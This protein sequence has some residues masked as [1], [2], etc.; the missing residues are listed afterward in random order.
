MSSILK[1][2]ARAALDAPLPLG[3]PPRN[4]RGVPLDPQVHRMM[5]ILGLA[6]RPTID[7]LGAERARRELLAQ[8][9][10][11]ARAAVPVHHVEDRRI[12][13]EEGELTVRVYVPRGGA[14]R[15]PATVYY[16]GGGFV[17]GDLESHDA[18][19]RHLAVRGGCVVVAVHYRLAPEHPFPA[20]VDDA[21]AAFAWVV[22][23]AGALG[24]DPARVAVAGDSAGGNLAAVVSQVARD[25]GGPRPSFQLL[26]YPATD[27][28]RSLASHRTFAEGYFLTEAM[29]DWF[30]ASYLT[31][32]EQQHDPRASPLRARDLTGL[33]PAHVV[34]AG[35]DPLRDEGE[36][37]ADALRA[38]GVPAT[39]RCYDTMIHGFVSMAG[40][41]DAAAHATDDIADVLRAHHW[42]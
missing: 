17:L 25:R 16:H 37:Y 14:G 22:A 2:L 34:T 32:P 31:D 4:D 28:T 23:N 36:A 29:I 8:S 35:F 40:L 5:A 20:A 3:A 19:C 38:A 15:L 18:H 11:G 39:S 33:P 9:R 7:Q 41:V 10:L 6:R 13:A 12:D 30:F 21:Y 1:P 24:V 27:M 26:V 42:R